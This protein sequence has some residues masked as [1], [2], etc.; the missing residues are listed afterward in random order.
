LRVDDD[1]LAGEREQ[2]LKDIILQVFRR[3]FEFIEE[4]GGGA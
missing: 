2:W 1:A 3:L 4:E